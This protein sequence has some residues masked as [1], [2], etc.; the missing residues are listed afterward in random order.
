MKTKYV[1]VGILILVA[2]A[3][4]AGRLAW[5]VHRQL[6]TLNVR[7]APLPEV[8]RSI[9]KQT[10]K[11]IRAEKA[12]ADVRVTLRVT[13]KP[14]SAVLDRLAAQAGARW[15]IR[16][17]VY[18]ST[19]ALN[20][21]DSTLRGEGKLEP[22]GWVKIAPHPE[23]VDHLGTG[24][25]GEQFGMGAGAPAFPPP[26]GIAAPEHGADASGTPSAVAPGQRRVMMVRRGPEGPVIFQGGPEGKIEM[27]SPEEV[28]IQSSLVPRLASDPSISNSPPT[29][30][31][32]AQVAKMANAKWTTY[33]A[34]AKS[35]FGLGLAGLPPGGERV[36]AAV[37]AK[38]G[39]PPVVNLRGP[40]PNARFDTLTPQQRV[41][42]ARERVQFNLNEKN[43]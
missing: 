9:E 22:A 37:T 21:L 11:K 42:R 19:T 10:W 24:A 29:A 2:A 8:L 34:F 43:P 4:W 13:N 39:G 31:T 30:A 41:Q 35:S 15:T 3:L 38:G 32:A 36:T 6:V 14:L 26:D 5:H 18:G 7:N 28:V 20:A 17:A 1:L 33:L 25:P 23:T 27:W 16:Y 12:L 40:N